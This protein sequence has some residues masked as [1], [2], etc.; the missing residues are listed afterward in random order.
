MGDVNQGA[1]GAVAMNMKEIK[2]CSW[3]GVKLHQANIPKGCWKWNRFNLDRS[4][5][6]FW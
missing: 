2:K 5:G 1:G 3:G 6:R 4:D